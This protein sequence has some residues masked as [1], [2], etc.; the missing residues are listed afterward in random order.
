LLVTSL[1]LFAAFGLWVHRFAHS[2]IMPLDIWAAPSFLPLI[3]VVIFSIMSYGI[4][5]WYLVA[6]QQLIRHW[7]PFHFGIGILPHGLVGAISAPI[8]AWLVSRVAA[9]WILGFGAFAVATSSIILATMPPHQIYWA[10]VFPAIILM[11]LC[12]DF[13]FTAAQIIATNSVKKNE[14][15]IAG[16]LISLLLLYSTSLGLGFAGTVESQT[17]DDGTAIVHGYRGALYL[18][19]GLAVAAL[20]LDIIF[21]RVPKDTREGWPDDDTPQISMIEQTNPTRDPKLERGEKN[22]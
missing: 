1:I 9:Q 4:C 6:W 22:I 18:A 17:N 8:A 13:I 16:S 10:Q 15:G 21:V 2:P 14:Q 12:P 7:S 20:A 19:A 11:A 5:I 3:F